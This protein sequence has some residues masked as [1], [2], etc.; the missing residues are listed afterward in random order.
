MTTSTAIVPLNDRPTD[1][2]QDAMQQLLVSDGTK[3]TYA[4]ENIRFITYLYDLDAD[5]FIWD[6]KYKRSRQHRMDKDTD[7]YNKDG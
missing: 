7:D 6:Q 5:E 1:A 4:L 3:D 2:V